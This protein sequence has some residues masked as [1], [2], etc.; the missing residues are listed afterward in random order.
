[1]ATTIWAPDGHCIGW[2]PDSTTIFRQCFF[3]DSSLRDFL[4]ALSN[5]DGLSLAVHMD[6]VWAAG[7]GTKSDTGIFFLLNN[8]STFFMKHD[9]IN[10]THLAFP[11]PK[12]FDEIPRPLALLH[13]VI[14]ISHGFS[15][16]YGPCYRFI[17]SLEK[18]IRENN[19]AWQIIIPD[20]RPTY[21]FET[22]HGHSERKRMLV[23]EMLC[24]NPR[25][26]KLVLI[27]HSQGG[28]VSACVC[29]PRIVQAA[30]IRGLICL[31]SENP[32]SYDRQFPRPNIEHISFI[33]ASGDRVVHPETMVQLG[34]AWG[35][36]KCE[37][38]QSKVTA[39]VQDCM[40]DDIAHG[41]SSCN[42]RRTKLYVRRS[43]LSV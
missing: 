2:Y 34:E 8:G 32:L 25:P 22:R 38:L 43:N 1:M 16:T 37:V 24:L 31:C 15:P 27:G 21:E 7:V 39:A 6:G 13:N 12:L 41:K 3:T 5:G 30:N 18:H 4:K 20:Y 33:H 9:E 28:A 29:S 23:E 42:A 10:A 36:A 35:V 19:P 26:S 11:P 40:G 14:I 17:R